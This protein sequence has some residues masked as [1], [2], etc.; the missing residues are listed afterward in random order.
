MLFRSYD[1]ESTIDNEYS[2]FDVIEEEGDIRTKM[3][4][5]TLLHRTSEG[6]HRD[7]MKYAY[8]E[9]RS[10]KWYEEM[11]R[12]MVNSCLY[13]LQ[14]SNCKFIMMDGWCK[15]CDE[16]FFQDIPQYIL[17]GTVAANYG[18]GYEGTDLKDK[19]YPKPEEHQ[20]IADGIIEHYKK[21]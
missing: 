17:R 7:F 11:F 2:K 13:H 14:K 16:K 5:F 20:K 10:D 19:S 6:P 1:Y 4:C 12:V 3:M 15:Q 8:R 9:M 21:I 18:R